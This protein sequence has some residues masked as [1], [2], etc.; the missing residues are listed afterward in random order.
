MIV[1]KAVKIKINDLQALVCKYQNILTMNLRGDI[2]SLEGLEYYIEVFDGTNKVNKGSSEVPY[3]VVVKEDAALLLKGDV[4]GD[5]IISTKDALMIMKHIEGKL[6]L[7]DD[8][9]KRA[10]LND[11]KKLNASE[12]LKILQ[13]IN[14]KIPSLK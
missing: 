14:G 2:V 7:K 9:F 11:D 1:Y 3:E 5:G 12:A 6:I 10:D 13:Y 4:D 8:E